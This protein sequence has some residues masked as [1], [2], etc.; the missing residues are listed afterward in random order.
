M[1]DLNDSTPT[2]EQ[3][4]AELRELH[5]RRE[6]EPLSDADEARYGELWAW[7]QSAGGAAESLADAE[8]DAAVLPDVPQEWLAAFEGEEEP[9]AAPATSPELAVGGDLV[10]EWEAWQASQSR[11]D[12][13]ELMPEDSGAGSSYEEL[14]SARA[15]ALGA[16]GVGEL[17]AEGSDLLV[18]EL[19]AA[20][21]IQSAGARDGEVAEVE[22]D[23]SVA[24]EPSERP[25]E[26]APSVA[27][28]A[29]AESARR[30]VVHLADGQVRRGEVL[31]LELAHDTFSFIGAGGSTETV[32]RSQLRA[33]FFM[34]GP[35]A[36]AVPCAEGAAIRVTLRD[37]RELAG[38]S[39]DHESGGDG[40]TV[41]PDAASSNTALVW[42]AR[43]AVRSVS[44]AG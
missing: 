23:L 6:R 44:R 24:Q 3:L 34:R 20:A 29:A 35:G 42:V 16:A 19:D 43:A 30:V 39:A 33:V 4:A 13:F 18:P 32:P 21:E 1:A 31:D 5:D 11:A 22:L 41:V 12:P 27:R 10:N 8:A 38:R 36:A 9:Q 28:S 37:G 26:S 25:A 14:M 2:A 17:D 40:F 7:W 15:E